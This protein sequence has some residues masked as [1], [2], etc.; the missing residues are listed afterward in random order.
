MTDTI[1]AEQADDLRGILKDIYARHGLA[2][3]Y[4]TAHIH[5]DNGFNA[6][7]TLKIVVVF[8]DESNHTF[9]EDLPDRAS[10]KEDAIFK[11]NDYL[12]N[13]G[14]DLW[15]STQSATESEYAELR[16]GYRDAA[17]I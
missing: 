13:K 5:G 7:P 1:T 16:K 17:A 9:N 12:D 11:L 6:E 10:A 2:R 15:A 4:K 8:T 14:I 3:I